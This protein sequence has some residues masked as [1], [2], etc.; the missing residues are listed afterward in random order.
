MLRGLKKELAFTRFQRVNAQTSFFI[1]PGYARK[2]RRSAHLIERQCWR[3][4]CGWGLKPYNWAFVPFLSLCIPLAFATKAQAV[5]QGGCWQHRAD[6]S[7]PPG[8]RLV[9]VRRRAYNRAG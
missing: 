6:T 2:K 8:A 4:W 1:F 7:L 5:E 3:C 9:G